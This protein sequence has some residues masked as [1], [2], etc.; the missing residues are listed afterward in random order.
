[1]NLVFLVIQLCTKYTN[2]KLSN[3]LAGGTS[4]A[5]AGGTSLALAGG[6]SLALAGG[7]SLAL[8]GGTSLDNAVIC[9]SL[10][11]TKPF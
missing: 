4:L 8:A 5:L 9:H 2:H 1:M 3:A 11:E 10:A 6:T 7:T